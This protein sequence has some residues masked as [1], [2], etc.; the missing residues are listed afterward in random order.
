MKEE[1]T[2]EDK[3]NLIAYAVVKRMVENKDTLV[4]DIIKAKEILNETE[5]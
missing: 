5:V 4:S 3:L 1:L 2:Q